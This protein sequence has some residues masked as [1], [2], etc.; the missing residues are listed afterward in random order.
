MKAKR[1]VYIICFVIFGILAQF[2]VHAGLE[3]AMIELLLKDF[4]RYGL[5]LSWDAWYFIHHAL[6]V[7]LLA[8][9]ALFGYR[10]GRY[11]WNVIYVEKRFGWPPKRKN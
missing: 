7:L 11:W 2:L 6:S 5:G 9:G 10:Q 4:Q 3:M 1:T 8:I